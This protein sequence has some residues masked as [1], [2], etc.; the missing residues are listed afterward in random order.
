PGRTGQ[1]GTPQRRSRSRTATSR[2]APTSRSAAEGRTSVSS[3]ID[4]TS[5]AQSLPP[6]AIAVVGMAG[7]FPGADSVSAFW[8]NLRDGVESI[9]DLSEDE[10]ISA[11]VSERALASRSYVR[12]AA[13]VP[14]I[15]E[16][17]A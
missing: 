15:D 13:L 5:A 6:N 4:Y 11:G 8:R 10:L 12:R 14:G 16:F 1:H 17:D 9:V 3:S 2:S 7:R